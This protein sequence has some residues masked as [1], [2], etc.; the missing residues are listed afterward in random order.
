MKTPVAF[1]LALSL[2]LGAGPALAGSIRHQSSIGHHGFI[3][4]RGPVVGFIHTPHGT[5]IH[6]H[7]TIIGAPSAVVPKAHGHVFVP[8]HGQRSVFPTYQ[9]PWRHWGKS[10]NGDGH[11]RLHQP[12]RRHQFVPG[13]WAWWHQHGWVWVPGRWTW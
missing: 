5:V 4:H 9:D 6:Q 3:G 12:P 10:F 8:V 13:H 7:G 1:A 2:V 11:S